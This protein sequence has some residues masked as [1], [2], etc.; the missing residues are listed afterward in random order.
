MRTLTS[1]PPALTSED[2]LKYSIALL[3]EHLTFLTHQ[4][5]HW[6]TDDI[7][8]SLVAA[9]AQGTS[10][11]AA[12]NDWVQ[13]PDSN[14]V[15]AVLRQC[16]D[17]ARFAE[18]EAATNACLLS[19]VPRWL[20]RHAVEVALDL[21]EEPFYG[22]SARESAF[23]AR[24]QAHCGTTRFYRVATAYVL[25]RGVRLT[26]AVTFL[27]KD[28][29]P[30]QAAQALLQRLTQAQI[31]LRRVYA[32]KGFRSVA[33]F[34]YLQAQALPAII[35]VPLNRGARGIGAKAQGRRSYRTTH[36][37]THPAAGRVTVPVV[38]VRTW[39]KRKGRRVYHWLGFVVLRLRAEPRAVRHMYRRRFGIESGY[40]MLEQV[41]I[42]TSSRCS[43]WHFF[44]IALALLL[45]TAWNRLQWRATAC[46][47]QGR[48]AVQEGVFRLHRFM[49]F[50]LHAVETRFHLQTSVQ[51][52]I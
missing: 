52:K 18:I 12:C 15:R 40:R 10:I 14:T 11:E 50:V 36:T 49:R 21:H 7:W 42:V 3:Q 46:V 2:T 26:L 41:R 44:F 25:Q 43:M 33:F 29:T 35:A 13:G 51:L 4:G 8:R 23:I 30:T 9:A 16:V 17:N 39:A 28:A 5:R 45:L 34:Q 32:D 48:F 27:C 6:Q 31:R 22:R 37:F 19:A 20:R 1:A 38:L 47:R 24:G